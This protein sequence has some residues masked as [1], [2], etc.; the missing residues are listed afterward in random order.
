M[1]IFKYNPRK[2]GVITAIRIYNDKG[3][4]FPMA[5]LAFAFGGKATIE[6]TNPEQRKSYK[7]GI[8]GYTFI[9]DERNKGD[10]EQYIKQSVKSS[11]EEKLEMVQNILPNKMLEYEKSIARN[12]LQDGWLIEQ[13]ADELMFG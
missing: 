8:N 1:A 4:I 6:W 9:F 7:D 5:E 12:H 10:F 3:K 11:I 2:D 13:V